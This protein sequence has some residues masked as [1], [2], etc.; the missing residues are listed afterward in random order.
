V[1]ACDAERCMA[2]RKLSPEGG[3]WRPTV[4]K[5]PAG[6]SLTSTFPH[7]DYASRCLRWP[8]ETSSF[9]LNCP[10]ERSHA[11][12]KMAS[13]CDQELNLAYSTWCD[14]PCFGSAA[15]R[16]G[17]A[18]DRYMGMCTTWSAL[19]HRYPRSRLKQLRYYSSLFT[20]LNIRS[21]KH[22]QYDFRVV[23]PD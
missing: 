15:D 19:V 21:T 14:P 3:S 6:D 2:L 5:P 8:P 9:T 7:H 22:R 23:R 13:R 12:R 18:P 11:D 4:H 10:K 20:L 17:D 1:Q 16:S